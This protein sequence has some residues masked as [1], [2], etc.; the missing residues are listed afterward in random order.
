MKTKPEVVTYDVVAKKIKELYDRDERI[1]VRNVLS[2]TGG[3]TNKIVEFIKRWKNE[4]QVIQDYSISSTLMVALAQERKLITK[5]VSEAKE[6]EITTLNSLLEE[7]KLINLE[8]EKKLADYA[9]T[10][11]DL[12]NCQEQLKMLER[13]LRNCRN[14]ADVAITKFGV[15]SQKLEDSNKLLELSDKKL[16]AAE[17]NK[18]QALD[19]KI[20]WKAKAEQAQDQLKDLYNKLKITDK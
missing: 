20:A 3:S 17:R 2:H 6:Q 19:D 15:I 7:L 9:E 13:E 1:S 14:S 11:Q 4:N 8:H 10:K 18:Q 16:K 12:I 5:M